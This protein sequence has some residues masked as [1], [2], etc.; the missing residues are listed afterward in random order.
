[1]AALTVLNPVAVPGEVAQVS[2]REVTSVHGMRIGVLD[3]TK[4]NA[5]EI[6]ER[7]AQLLV[8]QHGAA[9]YKVYRKL[10][11]S[12]G[13]SAKM[14]A[15]I[16]ANSDIVITGSGDC[17]GCTSWSALDAAEIERLGVPAVLMVT[18][19]FIPLAKMLVVQEGTADMSIA[20]IP[21]PIG[22][23]KTT[24]V[25]PLGEDVMATVLGHV[26]AASALSGVA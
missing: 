3:N 11:A 26:A 12:Q 5:V 13:A 19:A 8:E 2:V 7:A 20:E 21:H 22:G 9:S 25:L 24:E 17:G 6:M 18:D 16:A 14:L 4:P 1:M 15:E 10:S 23:K